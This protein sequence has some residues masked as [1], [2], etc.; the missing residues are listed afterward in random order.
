MGRKGLVLTPVTGEVS[1]PLP[2]SLSSLAQE[3]CFSGNFSKGFV[4]NSWFQD[5]PYSDQVEKPARAIVNGGY[6]QLNK[7]FPEES[8]GFGSEGTLKG[9]EGVRP[10]TSRVVVPVWCLVWKGCAPPLHHP[11]PVKMD[12]PLCQAPGSRNPSS[13]TPGCVP[14]V[15]LGNAGEG[16]GLGAEKEKG[17]KG[18]NLL[19]AKVKAKMQIWRS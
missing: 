6:V 1:I 16:A 10:A 19:R 2:F 15:F 9:E 18:E 11:V 7:V 17:L 4:G 5:E 3:I 8:G 13:H 12:K 14:S